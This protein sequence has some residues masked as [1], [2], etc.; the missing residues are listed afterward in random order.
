M[1]DCFILYVH[2]KKKTFIDLSLYVMFLMCIYIYIMDRG[3]KRDSAGK[4]G[5][6]LY[7]IEMFY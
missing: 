2:S 4:G 5:L 3:E 6:F 1:I 7:S